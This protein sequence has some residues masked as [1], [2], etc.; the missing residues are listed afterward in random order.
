MEPRQQQGRVNR[1]AC[2]AIA[3]IQKSD[4]AALIKPA[5]E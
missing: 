5:H 2:G 4:R 3:N 1:A